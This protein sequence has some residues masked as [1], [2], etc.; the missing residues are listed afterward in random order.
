MGLR[1][2]KRILKTACIPREQC[3]CWCCTSTWLKDVNGWRSHSAVN[4]GVCH[5]LL[6]L[7]PPVCMQCPCYIWRLAHGEQMGHSILTIRKQTNDDQMLHRHHQPARPTSFPLAT[8]KRFPNCRPFSPLSVI[9][10]SALMAFSLSLFSPVPPLPLAVSCHFNLTLAPF[11]C[12]VENKVKL[13]H[14]FEW[15]TG[16]ISIIVVIPGQLGCPIIVWLFI[17]KLSNLN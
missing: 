7:L 8:P 2:G 16:R 13:M 1:E 11:R 3:R 15:G 10:S 9:V 4:V 14:L 6:L 12:L 5:L 17:L